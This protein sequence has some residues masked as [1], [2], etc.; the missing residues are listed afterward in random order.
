MKK[1]KSISFAGKK[2][3]NM[4][5]DLL[6]GDNITSHETRLDVNMYVCEFLSISASKQEMDLFSL[7]SHHHHFLHVLNDN[8]LFIILLLLQNR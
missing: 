6:V 4:K 2:E 8:I 5:M 7:S 1:K 3:Y